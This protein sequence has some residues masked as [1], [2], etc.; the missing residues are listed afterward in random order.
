MSAVIVVGAGTII[1]TSRIDDDQLA[2][3]IRDAA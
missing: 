2:A 3:E 1:S